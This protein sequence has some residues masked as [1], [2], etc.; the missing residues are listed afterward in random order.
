MYLVDPIT[1]LT[2][3]SAALK[4]VDL[5]A[6]QI[7]RFVHKKPEPTKEEPHKVVT[8]KKADTIEVKREGK[9]VETIR[10]ADLAKLDD[11]SRKLIKTLEDSMERNYDLWTKVYPQRDTSPDPV[12][13]A[14]VEAQL[15]DIAKKMCCDLNKIFRFL[16]SIGKY[17]EDHYAH[18]QFVCSELDKAV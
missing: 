2:A 14:Q 8:E 6:N 9:I 11:S 4:I 18:V 15:K 3:V 16:D 5:V 13:N 12:R 7:D 10:P 1:T 17:L